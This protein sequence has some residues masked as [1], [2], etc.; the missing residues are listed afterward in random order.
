MCYVPAF[1]GFLLLLKLFLPLLIMNH[2]ACYY[3]SFFC[4]FRAALSAYGSSQARVESELQLP[5]YTT[6]TATPDLSLNFDLQV[7]VMLDP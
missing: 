2:L 7:S 5:A 4:L 3:L 6:A 1:P